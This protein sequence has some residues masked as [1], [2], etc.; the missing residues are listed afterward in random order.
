MHIDV[1]Y[2]LLYEERNNV[3]TCQA[4]ADYYYNI[5]LNEEPLGVEYQ[6]L[7]YRISELSHLSNIGE[8]GACNAVIQTLLEMIKVPENIHMTL[9]CKNRLIETLADVSRRKEMVG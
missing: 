8:I 1:L 9:S 5:L 2:T 3:I 7:Y 4:V 6:L